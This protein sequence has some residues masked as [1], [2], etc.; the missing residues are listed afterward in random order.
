MADFAHKTPAIGCVR[1]RGEMKKIALSIGCI[2]LALAAA[3]AASQ[4]IE[5]QLRDLKRLRDSG[6]ISEPVYAEQQRRI[7]EA[8]RPKVGTPPPGASEPKTAAA[9]VSGAAAPSKIPVVGATWNYRLQDKLFPARQQA[10]AVRVA[11]VNGAL[12]NELTQ[13]GDGQ[14]AAGALDAQQVRFV[15]R[16]I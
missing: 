10:F 3:Q 12:I 7:L 6:L 4:T 9:P 2:A 14:K 8:P 13:G 16:D 1:K 5:E 15:D 11:S